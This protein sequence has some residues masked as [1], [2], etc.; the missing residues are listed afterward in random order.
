MA[1]AVAKLP[2]RKL[3]LNLRDNSLG[4]GAQVIC[5]GQVFA[6]PGLPASF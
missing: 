5:D 2:L 6:T 3:E 4:P 1:A